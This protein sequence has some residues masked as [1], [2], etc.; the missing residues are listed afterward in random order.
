MADDTLTRTPSDLIYPLRPQRGWYWLGA[1]ATALVAT[2]LTRWHVEGSE[3]IPRSG[4]LIV[5]ANHFS[6]VDPPLLA[7]SLPRQLSYLG[8]VEL[9]A[10]PIGR[11]FCKVIGI[12]PLRRGA[13]DRQALRTALGALELGGVLGVFPEG[14]RG[15]EHPRVLKPGRNGVALLARMSG[16]PLIPV[17][18]AGTDAIDKPSDL[19]TKLLRRPEFTVR[20]GPAFTLPDRAGKDDLEALTHY[21]MTH[22]ARLL[23]ERYRGEYANAMEH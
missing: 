15:R 7:A 9:T 14:T 13:A 4:P 3:H 16:A 20:I 22:I 2:L 21:I 17:G 18:I 1:S 6:F 8:K 5:V 19:G 12:I 23:P 11:A 10:N